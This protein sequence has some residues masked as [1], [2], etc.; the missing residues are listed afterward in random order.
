MTERL[1]TLLHDEVD[2]LD[3]PAPAADTVLTRGRRERRR[4]QGG[5]VLGAAA[6]VAVVVAAAV[7]A[8]GLAGGDGAAPDPAAPVGD[9][10]VFAA[11]TRV[12]YD[13]PG[14]WAEID[15]K[16]VKSL[17][18]TSAGVLVRHG[19]SSASDGGGPQRFSL[20][21]PDGEVAPLGLVTEETVHASDPGQPYVAYAEAVDGELQAVVHD[22]AADAEAARVSLGATRESWFPV[23]LD[24]D[25][26]YVQDGYDGA[27]HAV[28]WRSGDST[29][30]DTV[31]H[32]LYVA[33]GHAVVSGRDRSEIVDVATG[34]R[35]LTVD[36]GWPQLSPDGRFV[37]VGPEDEGMGPDADTVAVHDLTSGSVTE[38]DGA[39]Y[40][41]GWTADGDLFRVGEETVTTCDPATGDCTQTGYEAPPGEP[42]EVCHS[43]AV[44]GGTESWCETLDPN[45]LR[46][47][48]LV[49]ES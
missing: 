13:G 10:P 41:W 2:R 26:L 4:R 31:Q 18:Y 27:V 7:G 36:G 33:G 40:D 46:L 47:G 15:D 21:S 14:A 49:Y 11:G 22:V 3:I 44:R 43:G 8:G 25:T 17:F 20:V 24:G 9:E 32:A 38:L 19:E 29:T 42:T 48:G 30:V 12:Y 45:E 1:S 28:D 23:S 16:A 6:A 35:L 34:E 5:R 37:K 39:S